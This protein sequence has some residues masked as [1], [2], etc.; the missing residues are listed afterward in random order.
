ML[1]RSL[2]LIATGISLLGCP[3]SNSSSGGDGD[4]CVRNVDCNA[5]LVCERGLCTD[6]Q[7]LNFNNSDGTV[8]G[9]T[10][11]STD[12][13]S[14]GS[15]TGSANGSSDGSNDGSSNGNSDGS[16]NGSTDGSTDGSSDGSTDG[17]RVRFALRTYSIIMGKVIVIMVSFV[18]RTNPIVFWV[19]VAQI[20]AFPTQTL[21]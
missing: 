20:V 14:D 13:S 1:I 2:F 9:S 21:F 11:G 10:T 15:S 19:G 5:G 8:D 18:Y 16:S 6:D 7:Q 4:S 12:G 3:S 17:S